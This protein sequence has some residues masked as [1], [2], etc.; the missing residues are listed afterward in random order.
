MYIICLICVY[1]QY[2]WLL[3]YGSSI[4]V[5]LKQ[6]SPETDA[7]SV[8]LPI[9]I[10]NVRGML[11][12]QMTEGR[13]IR[14]WEYT[15]AYYNIVTIVTM[16]HSNKACTS[17]PKP[18]WLL[19]PASLRNVRGVPGHEGPR[20]SLPIGEFLKDSSRIWMDLVCDN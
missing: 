11:T 2:I 3:L 20:L 6:R 12:I 14:I 4:W 10:Q 7:S 8:I 5:C 16:P 1:I 13:C 18:A 15:K 19:Q 9:C 17:N